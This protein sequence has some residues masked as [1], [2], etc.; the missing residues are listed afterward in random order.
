MIQNIIIIVELTY[1][2]VLLSLSHTDMRTRSLWYT[3]IIFLFRQT[4]SLHLIYLCCILSLPLAVSVAY[5]YVVPYIYT[6]YT[7]FSF[8]DTYFRFEGSRGNY[9]VILNYVHAIYTCMHATDAYLES[10]RVCV[11]QRE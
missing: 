2:V 9:M 3:F 8:G 4:S 6:I 5:H 10:K 1:K 7:H 11:V